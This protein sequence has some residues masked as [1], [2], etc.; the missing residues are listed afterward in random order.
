[1]TKESS[2]PRGDIGAREIESSVPRRSGY[3][4]QGDIGVRG[5]I[6]VSQGD[7]GARGDIGVRE[8]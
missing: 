1:M 5:D 2:A 3:R 8:I 4:R 6:G 7:R